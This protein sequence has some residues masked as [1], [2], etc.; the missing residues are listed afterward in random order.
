MIW[1]LIKLDLRKVLPLY[2]ATLVALVG[3]ILITRE[4]LD[5]TN[6]TV[7]VLA[8]A[9]GWILAYQ[10]F[11]DP[12]NTRV[13][14]FSRPWSRARIFW[15]RWTLAMTLQAITVLLVYAILAAGTRTWLYRSE[16]PYFPMV[17]SFEHSVLWPIAL[18]S[19]ITFHIIMFLMFWCVVMKTGTGWWQSVII[20][21]SL[22]LI[23]MGFLGSGGIVV[24]AGSQGAG[25]RIGHLACIYAAVLVFLCTCASLN[26]TKNMEI[27]S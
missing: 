26:C 2:L 21:I 25:L 9:Q 3:F 7:A 27:E 22:C 14:I 8:M 17:E 18:A 20:K 1:S 4:I 6:V 11:R 13:F 12:H 16:L 10:I 23:L 19:F 24:V 15:N 5:A